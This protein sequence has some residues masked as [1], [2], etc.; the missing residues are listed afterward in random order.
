LFQDRRR[1]RV[2]RGF[3]NIA[4]IREPSRKGSARASTHPLGTWDSPQASASMAAAGDL[5]RRSLAA[6]VPVQTNSRISR[7]A[8]PMSTYVRQITIR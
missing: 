1:Y 6:T 7:R 2:D 5:I 8:I 4:L 3:V